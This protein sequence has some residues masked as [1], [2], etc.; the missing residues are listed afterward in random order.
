[1]LHP[2]AVFVKAMWDDPPARPGEFPDEE[3]VQRRRLRL[4]V[5]LRHHP[6]EVDKRPRFVR[7][8]IRPI[9]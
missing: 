9:H 1:M 8:S 4:P 2:Y 3:V 6:D 7:R 5:L